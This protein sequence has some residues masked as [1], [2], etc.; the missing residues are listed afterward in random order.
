MKLELDS[1]Y[2]I[3]SKN[4]KLIARGVPRN[5][6]ICHIDEKTKKRILTYSSKGMAESGFK[7]SGFYLSD[8]S[9]EYVKEKHPEFVDA[10]GFVHWDDRMEE[11]FEAIEFK[12][13]LVEIK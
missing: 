10:Y 2:L 12:M 8:E 6:Y 4:R 9:K 5:R 3:L 11:Q 7:N 13:E 1:V